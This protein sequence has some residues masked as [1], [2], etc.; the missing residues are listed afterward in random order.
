MRL[1]RSATRCWVTLFAT[2]LLVSGA[3]T[4]GGGRAVARQA[5]P[6]SQPRQTTLAWPEAPAPARIE[7]VRV[8]TPATS[9]GKPSR[10]AR[11][12]NA[13]TGGD[14]YVPEVDQPYGIAVDGAGRVLA[15]DTF[16]RKIHVFDTLR[17]RYSRI[18][19][20]AE[21]L[22]GVATG[23]ERLYVTDSATA[24]VIALTAKGQRI[25]SVGRE[26]GLQRPTGIAIHGDRLYVVDTAVAQLLVFDLQGK[27]QG[28]IG[29]RGGRPGE[30]NFPTNVAVAPDGR[31]FVTDS[32]NFRVQW[33]GSDGRFLGMLGQLG[34]GSGDFGRPKGIALDSDGHIYV[35]E[36]LHDTV[37]VFDEQ[38][39]FLL[40]FGESGSGDGQFWLPTGIAILDDVIYVADAANKRVQVFK[41]LKERK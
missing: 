22:I 30:L 6:A 21:S 38:G 1:N 4:R 3:W 41:Y 39:H 23:G 27:L 19:V 18:D 36:G 17:S 32:M 8:L 26:A 34:D 33:F 15:A 29:S 13:V 25:W 11:F 20:D 9:G 5:R 31:V 7:F 2:G 37:Q 10:L 12:F 16:G 40:A 28:R 24:R 35:V 14:S